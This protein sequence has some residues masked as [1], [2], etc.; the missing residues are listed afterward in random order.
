MQ[1]AVRRGRRRSASIE[2][3]ARGAD[4]PMH[5]NQF[6]RAA[7][8]VRSKFWFA[9]ALVVAVCLGTVTAAQAQFVVTTTADS[10]PGSLRDAINQANVAGGTITFNLP[11]NST[12][13]TSA[14]NGALPPINN[15]VT[16][17]GSGSSGL[18]ISGGNANR[19]FFV[20]SGTVAISNLTIANGSAQGGAGGGSR[21]APGGGG[22]GAGGA[23]FVNAGSTTVSNVTFSNNTATGGVAGGS[24]VHKGTSGGGGGGGLGGSGGGGGQ[25]AGGGGGGYSGGGGGGGGSN[26]GSTF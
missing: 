13:A 11:A 2:G 5:G 4:E 7:G 23:I 25:D 6:A 26:D 9:T 8:T 19:V 24:V 22:L 15:N 21:S 1:Q 10:G 17:D 3:G 18:V 12:I 14:A 20:L 16:I